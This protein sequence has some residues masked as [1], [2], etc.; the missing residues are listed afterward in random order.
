[1]EKISISEKLR[2]F[3]K[4]WQSKLVGEFNAQGVKLAKIKG[5]FEWHNHSNEDELYLVLK[6]QLNIQFKS[7]SVVLEEGELFIVPRNTAHRLVCANEVNLMVIEAKS[8]LNID[9]KNSAA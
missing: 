5:E 2:S 8:S 7:E 3:D 9:S 4:Y 1:M 6:G